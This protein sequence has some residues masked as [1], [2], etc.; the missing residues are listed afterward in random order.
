MILTNSQYKPQGIEKTL[1]PIPEITLTEKLQTPGT[2][3]GK[4]NMRARD[5]RDVLEAA[6]G[7][8]EEPKPRARG[9]SLNPTSSFY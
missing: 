5:V 6:M 7:R 2:C 3:L 1:N 4:E 8:S 9:Q